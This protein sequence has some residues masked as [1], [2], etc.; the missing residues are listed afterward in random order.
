MILVSCLIL[1]AA[2]LLGLVLAGLA[3]SAPAAASD[4]LRARRKKSLADSSV[5][6]TVDPLVV[7]C[8]SLARSLPLSGHLSRVETL[9]VHAANPWGYAPEEYVGLEIASGFLGFAGTLV[10]FF[11]GLGDF[12][13]VESLFVGLGCTM[14][15]WSNL[16]S[17]AALRRRRIDRQMPYVLD[18]ISLTMGAGGTFLQACATVSEGE[19]VG[20][21]EEEFQTLQAEVNAGAP[22]REALKNMTKRT[23]SEELAIMV[24]AVCQG[25]ELGTPLV[26]I[27]ETQSSMNR[28]RRTKAAEQAAAKIP[29]RLAIPTVFLMLSVLILLF[30]PIIVKAVRGGMF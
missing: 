22:L 24:S 10:V 25:E 13:P 11:V 9:L 15:C 4:A 16:R 27:F 19:I 30:G 18:L 1:A 17:R 3:S 26:Q 21:I 7:A 28:Y 8:S 14:A 29:N 23:D 5:M 20:P 12:L 2:L 6:R